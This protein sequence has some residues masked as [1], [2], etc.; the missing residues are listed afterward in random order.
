M[1]NLHKEKYLA[2]AEIF[3]MAAFVPPA[4]GSAPHTSARRDT[5]T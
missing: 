5:E 1:V 4:D 2:I 3:C